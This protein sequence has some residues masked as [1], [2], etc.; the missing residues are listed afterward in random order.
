M[1]HHDDTHW[2][3]IQAAGRGDAEAR[4][5][6]A[7][8]Y[9]ALV[10]AYL[11]ARWRGSRMMADLEDATQ[12]VFLDCLRAGGPLGRVDR[13]RKVRF[14][15]FLF[16][17]V[18][19]VA[20]RHE[21]RAYAARRLGDSIPGGVG[22]AVSATASSVGLAAVETRVESA[23]LAFDR[24]WAR[25]VLVRAVARQRALA[26]AAGAAARER[27]ELLRMRLD[28]NLPI[29]EIARIWRRDPAQLHHEYAQARTE[30]KR[31]LRDELALESGCDARA[32]DA[33][34]DR[35]LEIFRR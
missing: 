11:G 25:A 8:R 6:F 26:D 34:C 23:S 13:G 5:A 35:L 24:A 28:E 15:S 2:T 29:R 12:D 22:G 9:Q 21:E 19:K 3:E 31:A 4:T 18:R 17:V 27:V 1:R 32:A 30:F 33:D 10:R 16:G 7:D 14:R 20:Q